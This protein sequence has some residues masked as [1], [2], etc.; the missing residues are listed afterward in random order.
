MADAKATHCEICT[1]TQWAD[2]DIRWH[3]RCPTCWDTRGGHAVGHKPRTFEPN[4]R[5]LYYVCGEG[6]T[7][8]YSKDELEAHSR[9]QELESVFKDSLPGMVDTLTHD[10]SELKTALAYREMQVQSMQATLDEM[11]RRMETL[12]ESISTAKQLS[13]KRAG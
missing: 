7:W 5:R 8:N 4:K 10:V 6:H 13:K 11:K 2:S 3:H 9:L 12:E 1:R